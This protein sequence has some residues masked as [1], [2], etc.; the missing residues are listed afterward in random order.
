MRPCIPFLLAGWSSLVCTSGT[1]QSNSSHMDSL[2]E[3]ETSCPCGLSNKVNLINALGF[4]NVIQDF[5][6]HFYFYR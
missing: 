1:E 2:T 4:Y 5:I 6:S 3:K